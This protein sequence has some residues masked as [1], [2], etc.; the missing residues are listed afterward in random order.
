MLLRS[1]RRTLPSMNFARR[2]SDSGGR[3][4]R[5]MNRRFSTTLLNLLSVRRTRKL[6]SCVQQLTHR[7]HPPFAV[8]EKLQ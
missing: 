5:D 2:E 8:C 7:G 1:G 6:Y 4:V 3:L